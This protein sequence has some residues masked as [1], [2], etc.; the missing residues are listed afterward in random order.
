METLLAFLFLTG[1][2][3]ATIFTVTMIVAALS[4]SRDGGSR[5]NIVYT[6]PN[7]KVYQAHSWVCSECGVKNFSDNI[8]MEMDDDNKDFARSQMPGIPEAALVTS[9]WSYIPR[10]VVCGNC[11][12]KMRAWN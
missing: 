1:L 10:E 9:C 7:V 3:L 12:T 6:P 4:R 11:Q 5:R 2:A 8:L